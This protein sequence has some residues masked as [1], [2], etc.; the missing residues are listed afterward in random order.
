MDHSLLTGFD[1]SRLTI[2]HRFLDLLQETLHTLSS[3]NSP[4]RHHHDQV[5]AGARST[6]ASPQGQE[7]PILRRRFANPAGQGGACESPSVRRSHIR[8]RRQT[9]TSAAC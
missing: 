3:L 8:S 1:R 6:V 5:T 9:P 4:S 2:D 7:R